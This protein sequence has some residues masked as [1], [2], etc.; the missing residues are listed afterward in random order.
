MR[1]A[2]LAIEARYDPFTPISEERRILVELEKFDERDLW[3]TV[4]QMDERLTQL[5]SLT[6]SAGD[7]AQRE[8]VAPPL[9]YP[10]SE[11]AH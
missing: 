3:S 8:D 4:D 6:Q 9:C 1:L 10:P 7:D 5:E 11:T 2:E